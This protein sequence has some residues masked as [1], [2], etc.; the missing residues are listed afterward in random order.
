VKRDDTAKALPSKDGIA[1]AVGLPTR[2]STAGIS[3]RLTLG[4]N[5]DHLTESTV[6]ASAPYIHGSRPAATWCRREEIA[7][8]EVC[9]A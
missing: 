7:N 9:A 5:G 1:R 3:Q 4:H 2:A 8:E 6:P